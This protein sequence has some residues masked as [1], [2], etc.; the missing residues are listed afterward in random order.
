MLTFKGYVINKQEHIFENQ[1]E[2]ILL[3]SFDVLQTEFGTNWY[4]F[5]DK[6][7]DNFVSYFW[8]SKYYF[9]VKVILSE[10]FDMDNGIT[11]KILTS[12]FHDIDKKKKITDIKFD[13]TSDHAIGIAEP[14]KL[15]GKAMYVLFDY[16]NKHKDIEYISFEGD[17]DQLK[18]IYKVMV[19]NHR[20]LDKIKNYGWGFK[21]TIGDKHTFQRIS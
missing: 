10:N 3:E 13:Y 4:E 7:Y 9:I 12:Y 14:Q 20:F 15:F 6:K 5:N 1:V 16:T 2:R 11:F 8:F 19:R 17:T 18:R 21:E